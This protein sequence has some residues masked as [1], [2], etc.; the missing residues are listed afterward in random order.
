[1]AH[2]LTERENGF[3]EFGYRG[4]PAWHGLGQQLEDGADIDTW[5]IQAGLDWSVERGEI[6]YAD[7]TNTQHSFPN[8]RVLFRSDNK[9]PLSIVSTGFKIVQPGEILEFFRDLVESHDM[10]LSAAGSL[11]G[12]TRFW[13]T[14]EL[15]K[16]FD[17]L[18]ND[19]VESQLLLTTSVD[20]TL[21]TIA[22]FVSLRVVCNNTMNVGLNET[23]SNVVRK[24]HRSDWDPTAV[25]IDLGLIDESWNQFIANVNKLVSFE[26]SDNLVHK[27]YQSQ[28]FDPNLSAN[29]Q[30]WGTTKRVNDLMNLYHNGAGADMAKGSGWGA[31]N[32]ITNLF[33]HGNGRKR[34][35][36]N[37]FWDGYHGEAANIKLRSFN[38]LLKLAA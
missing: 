13:A 17:A 9:K 29:D 25:K 30:T 4:E 10:K 37:L 31:L 15:G 33:T 34:N 24:T 20:S 38:N 21:A 16:S 28:F 22:K 36:S 32:A 12:G 11:F 26:M 23:S 35:Q 27:F 19:R 3:F 1:M 14:A 7:S 2:E 8:K 5:R 6:S 18:V